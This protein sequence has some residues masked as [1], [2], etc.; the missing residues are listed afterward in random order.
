M[1]WEIRPVDEIRAIKLFSHL[2]ANFVEISLN[3]ITKAIND[4]LLYFN[5]FGHKIIKLNRTKVIQE[6]IVLIHFLL[7]TGSV[8]EILILYIKRPLLHKSA[9]NYMLT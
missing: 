2:R 6:T 8:L 7:H 3:K 9:S 4:T 1:Y 5:I